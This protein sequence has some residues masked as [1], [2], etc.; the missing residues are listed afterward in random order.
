MHSHLI[1]F[2]LHLQLITLYHI[3][4]DESILKDCQHYPNTYKI[5]TVLIYSCSYLSLQMTSF[6]LYQESI[7]MSSLH[8][9]VKSAEY[10]KSE[11]NM[12]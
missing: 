2:I 5:P 12:T 1:F 6:K 7:Q 8:G 11:K 3:D 4:C 9:D 10:M